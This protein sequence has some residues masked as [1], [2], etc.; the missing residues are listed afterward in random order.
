MNAIEITNLT[1]NYKEFRL[2]NINL[3]LPGGCIMGLIGENGAGKTTLIKLLLDLV[4]RDS[5]SI[6]ILGKDNKDNFNVTKEDLG[7]VLDNV[8]LHDYMKA[9]HV[10]KIMSAAYKNWDSKKFFDLLEKFNV[11]VKRK[12]KEMSKGMKMK[13]GLAIALSQDAKLLILDEAT[14][15]LDPVVRDDL[16]DILME[17]T[18]DEN[19]SVFISSHI[20]SDLEKICDYIAFMHKG[21]IIICEEKDILKENYCIVQ[22][23]EEELAKIDKNSIIGIKRTSY[24]TEVMALKKD[25]P[26]G[27][28]TNPID[29]EQLFIFMVKEGK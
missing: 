26:K 4:S 1:K 21:K 16:L 23:N 14:S 5:G 24:R 3:T 11:P 25:L 8:G 12:F 10:E 17:F 27:M 19:H 7:I 20:V 18:L 22:C 9:K 13:M 28:H 2:D 6:K 15:G 29:I